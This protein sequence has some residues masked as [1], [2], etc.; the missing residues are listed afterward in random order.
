MHPRSRWL[1]ALSL[2]PALAALTVSF[3]Y[4]APLRDDRS[5]LRKPTVDALK[6]TSYRATIPGSKVT[7][8]MVAIPGGTFL[9]GST[10]DEKGRGNDEGPRHPVRISPFWMGKCEVTWDEFEL[11]YLTHKEAKKKDPTLKD[12]AADAIT[13][14]S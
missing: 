9:M 13:K 11:Y 14:P 3:S 7:F 4:T 10:E 6:H 12:T 8:D 5:P 1:M 2:I